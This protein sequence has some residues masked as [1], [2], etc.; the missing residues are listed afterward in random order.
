VRPAVSNDEI[1]ALLDVIYERYHYDFRHYA[2]AS[3]KRRLQQALVAMSCNG[4]AELQEKIL[5]D[6]HA[7]SALLS[8]L[9]VQVTDLFRDPTF[10][11]ALR[12]QVVPLLATYP[13]LK[14]WV[15]GC[16]T[17]EEAY[18]LA[19][20][21]SEA[22]LLER[23]LIYATDIN[24]QSLAQARTGVYSLE[25][26]KQYTLNHRASGG[27]GSLS[28]Y[29]HAARGNALMAAE[30]RRRITFADHSLATDGIFSEVQMVCCRNVLI[31]FDTE[32]R[33][34]ALGLFA[35]ALCPRGFLCL[36]TKESVR[37]SAQAHRFED[38]DLSQKI[39]RRVD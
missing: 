18:S 27:L 32:L 21:L 10:Y 37:F 1:Q 31:Y 12:P 33:D 3:L 26:M 20:L 36:G 29:Y 28:E 23:T 25:R 38:V 7:F 34:R 11:A 39:Y 2:Q 8:Y 13:S 17:G 15:A 6:P 24:A 9:T 5:T 22:A 19:I 14:I 30:L 4:I 16:S 35:E